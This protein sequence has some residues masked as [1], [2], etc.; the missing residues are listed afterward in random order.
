MLSQEYSEIF[1]FSEVINR[2]NSL[3]EATIQF[4]SLNTFKNHL[5]RLRNTR[6]GFFMDLD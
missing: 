3:S 4:S 2:W 1:L 6:M 5:Q